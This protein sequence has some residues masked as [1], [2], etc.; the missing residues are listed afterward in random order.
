MC[1]SGCRSAYTL[2]VSVSEA[3]FPHLSCMSGSSACRSLPRLDLGEGR[4]DEDRL[5]FRSHG[6]FLQK[7][8][9]GLSNV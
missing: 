4:V 7:V 9:W 3:C 2:Y 1:A 8:L 6:F 5:Q